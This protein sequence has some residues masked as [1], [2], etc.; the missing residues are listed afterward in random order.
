MRVIN[1]PLFFLLTFLSTAKVVEKHYHYH[2]DIAAPTRFLY[3]SNFAKLRD[4]Y[5][6][7]N[8]KVF[9]ECTNSCK[10]HSGERA[11][12][13]AYGCFGKKAHS[14]QVNWTEKCEKDLCTNWETKE[15]CDADCSKEARKMTFGWIWDK[16]RKHV[17]SNPKFTGWKKRVFSNRCSLLGYSIPRWL[18][19]PTQCPVKCKT[20]KGGWNDFLRNG[21]ESVK[22]CLGMCPPAKRRRRML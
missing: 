19:N 16:C 14:W 5:T 7:I 10:R 8:K 12:Y 22:K 20:V 13:C 17:A 15:K 9:A 4:T 3:D 18:N 21:E 11:L 6:D 1:L 2:F